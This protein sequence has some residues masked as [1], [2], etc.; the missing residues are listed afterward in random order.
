MQL[1]EVYINDKIVELSPDEVV[2][3]TFKIAKIG[4]LAFVQS[5][6][7][8]RISAPY[9][10]QNK[11]AFQNAE[12]IN[13]QTGLPYDLNNLS[14]RQNGVWILQNGKLILEE[15]EADYKFSVLSGNINLFDALGDS[16][17]SALDLSSLDEAW[18]RANVAASINDSATFNY[19]LVNYGTVSKNTDTIES[20]YLYPAMYCK[21]IFEKIITD[22]GFNIDVNDLTG[23]IYPQL[24]YLLGSKDFGFDDDNITND[25][26]LIRW[27]S[28]TVYGVGNT[29][30]TGLVEDVALG[31]LQ[32]D[33]ITG[34][35]DQTLGFEL[36]FEYDIDYIS[37]DN[38]S[39]I[40]FD[41][42]G[43]TSYGS[44]P[45][46]F[47]A[48]Q[49]NIKGTVEIDPIVIG[50]ED[51]NNAVRGYYFE[52]QVTAGN[53]VTIYDGSTITLKRTSGLI[54][55]VYDSDEIRFSQLQPEI[56][57]SDFIKGVAQTLGAIFQYNQLTNTIIVR[58]FN[59]IAENTANA[60][61]WSDKVDFNI[62][63]KIKYRLE[64]YAQR[65]NFLYTEDE[66]V[67][68]ENADAVIVIDDET[69][70][71]ETDIIQ[72]PF[73]AS[74]SSTFL[75]DNTTV[76]EA[77]LYTLDTDV[78]PN[79][80]VRDV[81]IEPRLIYSVEKSDLGIILSDDS[82]TTA[83]AS[84]RVGKFID[85]SQSVNLGWAD[86]LLTE[87]WGTIKDILEGKVK[88]LEL[89]VRLTEIDIQG[90]DFFKPIYLNVSDART[91]LSINGY[92]YIEEVKEYKRGFSTEVILVLLP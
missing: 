82:G 34:D 9:T 8:N 38:L 5:D 62:P 74:E 84:Y 41:S 46:D 43:T 7:S 90:L 49:T 40:F 76:S 42:T 77:I 83:A 89:Y 39:I 59:S 22:Q 73:A 21:Y 6:L 45:L 56:N 81:E 70:E 86:N 63:P 33:T 19:P 20:Q 52:I 53:S 61:D 3:L 69:L 92:F 12:Q 11:E 88:K 75:T 48:S 67:T 44:I 58:Q 79:V 15:F 13:N 14:I 66:N 57:Q 60:I 87:Y 65:N 37:S 32:Y 51:Y 72:L 27:S 55:V 25:D 85:S 91:G 1:L 30:I 24:Q 2:A 54:N 68:V 16:L 29:I 28:D 31:R 36:S 47:V 23:T 35:I 80:Y 4:E 71:Y 10:K 50:L 64:G 78:S 26:C 17:L 18:S